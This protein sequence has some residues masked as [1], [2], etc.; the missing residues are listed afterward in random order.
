[1]TKN[2]IIYY[3]SIYAISL[4]LLPVISTD[5]SNWLCVRNIVNFI[6]SSQ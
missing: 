4:K 6:A 1:M 2:Y 5:V 3:K